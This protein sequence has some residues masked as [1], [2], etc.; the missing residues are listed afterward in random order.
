MV[1]QRRADGL[2]WSGVASAGDENITDDKILSLIKIFS[3]PMDGSVDGLTG[4]EH[5]KSVA[6]AASRVHTPG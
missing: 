4:A 6:G 1:L 2:A 5:G 3:C